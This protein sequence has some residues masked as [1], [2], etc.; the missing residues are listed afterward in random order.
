M[1]LSLGERLGAP[2]GKHKEKVEDVDDSVV[3]HIR[4]TTRFTPSG[5][6][7][8]KIQYVNNTVEVGVTNRDTRIEMDETVTGAEEHIKPSVV[9]PIAHERP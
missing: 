9:I 3:V 2:V 6:D 7:C 4:R 8:K 1:R 5:K